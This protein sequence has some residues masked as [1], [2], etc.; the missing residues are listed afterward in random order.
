MAVTAVEFDGDREVVM[1]D[2]VSIEDDGPVT[3]RAFG[4]RVQRGTILLPPAGEKPD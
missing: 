3:K 2:E 4:C 1:T